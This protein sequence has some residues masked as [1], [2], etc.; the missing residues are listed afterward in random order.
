M[1]ATAN[2]LLAVQQRHDA[3]RAALL[4]SMPEGVEFS[5][6][7]DPLPLVKRVGGDIVPV[8]KPFLGH[9]YEPAVSPAQ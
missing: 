1:T 9:P 2:E 4:A 8:T 7:P 3:A 5:T 6:S